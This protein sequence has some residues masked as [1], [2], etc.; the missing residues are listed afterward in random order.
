[1]DLS[2]VSIKHLNK[3]GAHRHSSTLFR[4]FKIESG[5]KKGFTV[6]LTAIVIDNDVL[7]L[8]FFVK[9]LKRI[10]VNLTRTGS[11]MMSLA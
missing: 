11:R 8:I 3:L 6:G 9:N 4:P 5:Y 10:K 1:M 7:S 2:S